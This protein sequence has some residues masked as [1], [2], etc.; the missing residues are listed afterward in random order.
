MV[1]ETSISERITNSSERARGHYSSERLQKKQEEICLD[2]SHI[3]LFPLNRLI[4]IR[5]GVKMIHMFP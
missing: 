1:G 3:G 2:A 5:R 4:T